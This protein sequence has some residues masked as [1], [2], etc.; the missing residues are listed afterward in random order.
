[1][2]CPVQGSHAPLVHSVDVEIRPQGLDDEAKALA[3]GVVGAQVDHRALFLVAEGTACTA[4]EEQL[5]HLR[6]AVEASPVEGRASLLRVPK[7]RGG[8]DGRAPWFSGEAWSWELARKAKA[9][10]GRGRHQSRPW[11]GRVEHS[12]SRGGNKGSKPHHVWDVNST[13][14][15]EEQLSASH[16]VADNGVHQSRA[17]VLVPVVHE[18][19]LRA[20]GGQQLG[21]ALAIAHGRGVMH[22][23]H[24]LRS[25]LR[26]QEVSCLGTGKG[27]Q[28][29]VAGQKR[30]RRAQMRVQGL[31]MVH[32]AAR[33]VRAVVA[34]PANQDGVGHDALS[35]LACLLHPQ[36]RVAEGMSLEVQLVA[37]NCLGPGRASSKGP[38]GE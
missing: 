32:V 22:R 24:L 8:G 31:V 6:P 18:S 2:R 35:R 28:L 37:R 3:V 33:L 34:R 11:P 14:A 17:A 21:K 4:C 38:A 7:G 10:G 5:H 25:L 9:V 26:R 27:G 29:V 16:L 12:G 13:A 36:P 19:V 30:T 1:M 23:V 20:S 15:A